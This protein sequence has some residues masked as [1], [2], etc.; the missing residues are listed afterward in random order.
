MRALAITIFL[1]AVGAGLP[2]SPVEA[3]PAPRTPAYVWR[4]QAHHRRQEQLKRAGE[5]LSNL[6]PE[7]AIAACQE[8][9]KAHELI[10]YP[11]ATEP[12]AAYIRARAHA[13][14]GDFRQ[15][16]EWWDL[17]VRH[18]RRADCGT[19]QESTQA[20]ALVIRLVWTVASR[21]PREAEAQLRLITRG[22]FSAVSVLRP[23]S[24]STSREVQ[25]VLR[26]LAPGE[27]SLILGELA[28]KRGR[29]SEAKRFFQSARGSE[30]KFRLQQIQELEEIRRSPRVFR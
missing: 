14:L 8:A 21:P 27:A 18:R 15:A 4:D 12:T 5:H 2:A 28:F 9:Q 1:A 22:R 26:S 6:A 29:L 10:G 30:A 7:A 25:W 13:L 17:Y 23:A 24:E 3:L 19:C 20:T 16:L 11:P